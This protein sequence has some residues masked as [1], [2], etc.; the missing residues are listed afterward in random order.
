[1]KI[2]IFDSG[3]GGLIILKDIIAKLPN[4]DYMY[5]G[6]TA[7]APYGG[8]SPETIYLYTEQATEWLF[9]QGCEIIIVACNTSSAQ[10]LRKIQQCYLPMPDSGRRILGVVIPTVE[11]VLAMLDQKIGVMATEATVNSEVYIK[12]FGKLL[13]NAQVYQQSAPKLVPLIESGDL[14]GAEK[15]ALEY[16]QPLLAQN[17]Q[18]LILGC[19]H[20]GLLKD[21]IQQNLPAGIKVVSQGEFIPEKLKNYLERHP[22]LETKLTKGAQKEFFVTKITPELEKRAKTWFGP[23]AN[24]KLVNII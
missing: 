1:M 21:K 9:G 20:Y 4:Y 2:G 8:Q 22:E 10:A 14:D 16:I 24:L 18:T 3:T 23:E 7:R 13:P 6:D 17:I 12:E 5:L 11:S 15:T 19:T